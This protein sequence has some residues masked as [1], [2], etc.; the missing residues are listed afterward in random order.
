MADQITNVP[1]SGG[2]SHMGTGMVIGIIVVILVIIAV[3][4][5]FGRGFA[6]A[7]PQPT[8]FQESDGEVNIQLPSEIDVNLQQ[9]GGASQ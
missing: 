9:P 6:P 1:A 4:F 2:G 3:F 8:G 5:F 7:S